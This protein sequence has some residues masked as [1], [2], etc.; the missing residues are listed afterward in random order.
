MIRHKTCIIC[1]SD[2]IAKSNKGLYCKIM[3]RDKAYKIR[4]PDKVKIRRNKWYDRN[5]AEIN[6]HK[7]ENMKEYNRLYWSERRS[8]DIDFRLRGTMR[9]RFNA[10]MRG[11]IKSSSVF[12]YVG[13]TLDELK[14][15][16]ESKFQ[17]NMTW[18]NYGKWHID[19]KIPLVAFS[20]SEEDLHKAWHYSNLQPLWKIDNLKK[21]SKYDKH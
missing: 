6:R 4:N 12:E 18:E 15:H 5:K 13:C 7:R 9:N 20:S 1:G 14:L 3:C 10:A 2:F 16:L 11:H 21:G 8:S 17:V 19:H